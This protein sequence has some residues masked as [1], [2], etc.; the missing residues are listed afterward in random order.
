MF[1][2][3]Y[4]EGAVYNNSIAEMPQRFYSRNS[5]DETLRQQIENHLASHPHFRGRNGCVRV[6]VRKGVVRVEGCL[7]SWYL[8][9]MLQEAVQRIPGVRRI[10]NHTSVRD[11]SHVCEPEQK[12]P[13]G[14]WRESR[15][16][17]RVRQEINLPH[18]LR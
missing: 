7:P 15:P 9:Q 1:A 14:M 4:I 16:H 6:R 2:E 11:W 17:F 3:P 10:S 18:A 5:P 12:E 13:N 8:K